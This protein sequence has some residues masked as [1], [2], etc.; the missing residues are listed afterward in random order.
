MIKPTD[1]RCFALLELQALGNPGL[2]M[3]VHRCVAPDMGRV[4]GALLS[5][6][7]L[8]RTRYAIAVV[9]PGSCWCDRSPPTAMDGWEGWEFDPRAWPMPK[10]GDT[11][12][13][14]GQPVTLRIRS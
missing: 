7:T 3:H 12:E 1:V 5:M 10:P 11:V 8:I 9:P 13:M 4:V 2:V 6:R 14:L